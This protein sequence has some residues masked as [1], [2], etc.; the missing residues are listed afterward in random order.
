MKIFISHSSKDKE[1][2]CN[3][4]VQK[5]I[6]RFG[7]NV[8][9]YDQMTFEAGERSIDEINRTLEISDLYVI[10]LSDSAVESDWV[11]YELSQAY[12]KLNDKKLNRIYP[13]II[14]PN[15]KYSD[16]RI[17]EWLQKEYNLKYIARPSKAAKLISERA[18][19]VSWSRKT[20]IFKNSDIF[21]GRNNLVAEFENRLDDFDKPTLNTYV[22]SGIPNI[23]RKSLARNCLIKGNVITRAYEFAQISLNYQESIEDFL[24][25]TN[26]LGFT[27]NSDISEIMTKTLEEKIKCAI[28]MMSEIAEIHEIVLIKDEGC[29]VDYRGNIADWFKSIILSTELANRIVFVIITKYKTNYESV[30]N[31]DCIY[32]VNVPELSQS[33]RKGLLRRLSESKGLSLTRNV[34]DE[35]SKYLTGYPLQVYHAID[36]ITKNGLPYL[37]NNYKLLT[38]YNEQEVSS[39]LSEYKGNEK[40]FEILALVSKYDAISVDMLYDILNETEDYWNEYEQLSRQ[41]I[42][43]LEGVNG[44]YVRL[45]EV[46]RSYVSRS[47][48]KPCPT[49]I[50]K[51]NALFEIMFSDDTSPW[52]NSN[53]FLLAIRTKV[54]QRKIVEP[55]Y[56]IPSVYLKAMSDL[57]SDMQ[58][59]NV[60]SLAERALENS[61]NSDERI[62]YEIKYWLCAALAKL[63]DPKCL[64]EIKTLEMEHGLFLQAF[65]YRQIGKNDKA[66][67]KLDVLLSKRP[68]MSKAKREKVLVLKNLQQYERAIELA[69]ENYYLYPDNPYH[70][71]AYFDCLINIYFK[72]PNNELLSE[73]LERLGKIQSEKAQSMYGRCLSL[74]YAYVDKDYDSAK[75]QIAQ[76]IN[77]YPK[78]KKYALVVLFDIELLYGD[79]TAME[80]TIQELDSDNSNSNTIIICKSK[81]LA[82]KGDVDTAKEFFNKNIAY[83]TDESKQAFCDLLEKRY[84]YNN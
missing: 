48:Y 42:F 54:K 56:I 15:L 77:D 17:P 75:D 16:K 61:S 71:H 38:D 43:E 8:V 51:A 83:F 30:K 68:N 60:V 19:D 40:V 58:Y 27:T 57:Y 35:I 36:I 10:L 26:D 33:E 29:I 82:S 18:K 79:I 53:D 31:I 84:N 3:S 81:L 63:K 25:K 21:V 80:N 11:G 14:D 76:T 20:G 23:G 44:E 41:S 4:V 50:R 67:E 9:V 13:I 28:C 59:E 45:N 52:Y 74:Y 5:L 1:R 78:D 37:R 72:D 66:L 70:I 47:N 62:L 6:K 49:H 12:Q 34:F 32:C 2:Y 64:N 24:I 7:E 65:Y 69:K 55:K 46:V 22:V 73:L 39:L